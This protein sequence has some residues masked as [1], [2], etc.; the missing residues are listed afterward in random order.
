[1]RAVF[2]LS[3]MCT[4][5]LA[6]SQ[7]KPLDRIVGKV[8][9][10]LVLESD[11]TIQYEQMKLQGYPVDES[12]KCALFEDFMFQKLLLQQAELDSVEVSEKEVEAEINRRMQYH[13]ARLGGS[14]AEFE[15]HYGSI[16]AFKQQETPVIREEMLVRE[17]RSNIVSN[18]KI[19]PVEIRHYFSTLSPDSLPIVPAKYEIA[20]ILIKPEMNSFERQRVMNEM[21]RVRN[22]IVKDGRDF[23]M[24]AKFESM[25]GSKDAG[26]DLGYISREQVVSE[27]AAVAFRMKIGEVSD[28]FESE[29]GFHILQVLERKGQL[30]RVRHILKK[31]RFY[32]TDILKAKTRA[33]SLY[34]LLVNNKGSFADLASRFSQD[35][36][37]KG[38]GGMI[39]NQQSGDTKFAPEDLDPDIAA[40]ISHLN[41]GEITAP[42]AFTDYSGSNAVRILKL[43]TYK[44]A[45]R[46][47][48]S[49]DYEQ[50]KNAALQIKQQE[51]MVKWV[52]KKLPSTFSQVNEGYTHCEQSKRWIKKSN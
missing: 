20:E 32:S 8:G 25:D 26:G 7:P 38:N 14:E 47:N 15:K 42:E 3:L 43:V 39:T 41:E 6:F 19:T 44:E 30:L 12:S 49:D 27:F 16:V 5:N 18:I 51:A 21:K 1:M 29:F 24:V 52:E 34:E 13:L 50:I 23:G 40:R 45:H 33:D 9:G 48:L 4:A 37:S 46:A 2:F 22:D 10:S 28:V 17:M 35:A 36:A 31:P 11:I